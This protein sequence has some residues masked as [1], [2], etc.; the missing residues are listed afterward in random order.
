MWGPIS[1]QLFSPDAPVLERPPG[2]AESSGI[3]ARGTQGGWCCQ[4]WVTWPRYPPKNRRMPT[5]GNCAL[6]LP[7]LKGA[8][9]QRSH[10]VSGHQF[11][12]GN[13]AICYSTIKLIQRL[14]AGGEG[15]DRGWDGWMASPTQWTWVCVDSGSWWWTGRPGMLQFIRSQ[16][17]RHDWVTEL[18]W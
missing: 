8:T 17:V 14:R 3:K 6:C 7:P 1:H 16:R 5:M 2:Q 12:F 9:P 18:N 4:G 15:D 11:S 13:L 10:M